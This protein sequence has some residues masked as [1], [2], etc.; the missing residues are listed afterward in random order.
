MS[1]FLENVPLVFTPLT[2]V[3]IGCGQDFAAEARG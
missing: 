3:H 2:P 1:S